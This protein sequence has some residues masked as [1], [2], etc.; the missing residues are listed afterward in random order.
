MKT[1]F[2]NKKW[3]ALIVSVS[4]ILFFLLRN[5]E[6]ESAVITVPVSQGDFKVTVTVTG[7][8]EAKDKA[9]I[10]A[11]DEL[12][13]NTLGYLQT[14]IQDIV[15]EGT[16][17]DS[18][19]YV[20]RLDPSDLVNKLSQIEIDIVKKEASLLKA[21]L[22]TTLSI[23]GL[24][25]Q[26]KDLKY[27]LEEKELAVKLSEYEPEATIRKAKLDLGQTKRKL[28]IAEKNFKIK[29][30]KEETKITE[31][32]MALLEAQQKRDMYQDLVNKFTVYADRSGMVVYARDR[33][34]NKKGVGAEIAPWDLAVAT[35]PDMSKMISRTF[36]NEI[37]IN[38]LSKGLTVEVKLDAVEE[39]SYQGTVK[40]IANIGTQIMGSDVKLFEVLIEIEKP[41]SIMKP[42]MTTS[43]TIISQKLEDVLFV[44][45]EA[46][47]TNDSLSYVFIENRKQVV[48]LGPSN[49]N[50]I[51]IAKGL[52][53]SQSVLLSVPQN[54]EGYQYDYLPQTQQPAGL[55][56]NL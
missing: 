25:N 29:V 9:L 35:L 49:E 39:R 28:D 27:Q 50:F 22:D 11:P 45:I 6:E 12:R 7:E 32:Q 42:T 4:A 40:S 2:N 24:K 38:K 36:V 16:L 13:N 5:A 44:P 56:S 3:I 41:D 54:A 10:N 48:E 33:S 43:N 53:S 21:K 55:T 51:V 34:G 19:E 52:L 26:I 15:S 31:A 1:I 14:K 8:L 37:D 47:H 20:A 18:G 46:V 23:R 17:V 30:Q